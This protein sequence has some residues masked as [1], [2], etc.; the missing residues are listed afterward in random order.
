MLTMTLQ[1][2]APPNGANAMHMRRQD[3]EE[4]RISRSVQVHL[5][6]HLR[7]SYRTVLGEPVPQEQIELLLAFRRAER[8][9]RWA[10]TV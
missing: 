7:A 5:G 2:D 1:G 10:R 3:N 8:A 6:S 9:R 4:A